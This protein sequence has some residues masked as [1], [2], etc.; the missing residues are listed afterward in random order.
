MQIKNEPIKTGSA[1]GPQTSRAQRVPNLRWLWLVSIVS[2][3]IVFLALTAIEAQEKRKRPTAGGGPPAVVV[4][5]LVPNSSALAAAADIDTVP[6]HL[7]QYTRYLSLYNILEA[8]RP[9]HIQNLQFMI[10]SISRAKSLDPVFVVPNSDNS[11]VR[12]CLLDYQFYDDVRKKTF[13]WHRDVYEKLA[14]I[15]P[16]FHANLVKTITKIDDVT[17]KVIEQRDTYV[18]ANPP[19]CDVVA[20]AK[21][22][23]L[24]RSNAPLLRADW[25]VTQVSLPPFYYDLLDTG[26][27]QNEFFDMFFVDEKQLDRSRLEVRGVVV[28]SGAGAD[29]VIRVARNQRILVRYQ[30]LTGFIWLTHDSKEASINDRDYL[31]ILQNEKFDAS[32]LI[33]TGRNGMQLYFLAVGNAGNKDN[34]KEGD[35]QDEVPIEAAVDNTNVDRRVRNGRSCITCHADGIRSFRPMPQELVKKQIEN[36]FGAPGANVRMD[37][38]SPHNRKIDILR[39]AYIANVDEFVSED[40]RA[41]AKA[42]QRATQ[43]QWS[44]G[45]SVAANAAQFGKIYDQYQEAFITPEIAA[46]ECGLPVK[47]LMPLLARA[48]NDPHLSGL[49]TNDPLFTVRRDNWEQS[50]Q[51]AMIL[52]LQANQ[53]NRK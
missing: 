20:M 32:E 38:V 46:F 15:D 7:Q 33:G 31:R 53:G 30:T 23:R 45:I 27:T 44:D 37:I 34:I 25:F 19:W 36:L 11:V 21:L 3:V 35:R 24:T 5:Y 42:V 48:Q 14:D 49:A 12:I 17:N 13:G 8:D 29:G 52:I 18:R 22:V 50:F 40:Q 9:R 4:N 47:T 41:Y 1:I 43:T 6:A 10:H 51:Q 16:Y 28:K 2:A 39:D 26:K